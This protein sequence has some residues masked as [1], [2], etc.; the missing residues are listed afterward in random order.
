MCYR[1]CITQPV[2]VTWLV[3]RRVSIGPRGTHAEIALSWHHPVSPLGILFNNN[4]HLVSTCIFLSVHYTQTGCNSM[5]KPKVLHTR[6]TLLVAQ[7]IDTAA[8][9]HCSI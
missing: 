5:Q 1:D 3:R 6:N 7:S 2:Q 4:K 9:T 8:L